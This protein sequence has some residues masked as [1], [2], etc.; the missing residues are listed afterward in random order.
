MSII[1]SPFDNDPISPICLLNPHSES[2]GAT[3]VNSVCVFGFRYTHF[4]FH[5]LLSMP[6]APVALWWYKVLCFL[7]GKERKKGEGNYNTNGSNCVLSPAPP[8]SSP[9]LAC[10]S[11]CGWV[12][13][14]ILSERERCAG[15]SVLF[16]KRRKKKKKK[17]SRDGGNSRL[18]RKE[19]TNVGGQRARLQCEGGASAPCSVRSVVRGRGRSVC[20]PPCPHHSNSPRN[21]YS[22]TYSYH[23][24]RTPARRRPTT[25]P[26]QYSVSCQPL[27][28]NRADEAA[29]PATTRVQGRQM[30]AVVLASR[31][32][33][34]AV[35]NRNGMD[36]LRDAAEGGTDGRKE[37]HQQWHF[38]PR[39]TADRADEERWQGAGRGVGERARAR[40]QGS[41]TRADSVPRT[42]R[43]RS[44]PRGLKWITQ[45]RP[46]G[47]QILLKL[48]HYDGM[49]GG[50][51]LF[52]S[53]S[54]VHQ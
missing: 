3:A 43:S 20:L 41:R 2:S 42:P 16:Q 25:P 51:T 28:A 31:P 19:G 10:E 13:S 39:S 22:L 5:S 44:Y 15:A 6:A 26:I 50:G 38:L 11:L 9:S 45:T 40:G 27:C 8:P 46:H 36:E 23:G 54:T 18:P 34:V 24:D 37:G 7:E 21:Q 1:P 29:A 17:R 49:D 53:T 35:A 32:A 52:Q 30:A 48:C 12:S 14:L 47:R 33:P 4:R